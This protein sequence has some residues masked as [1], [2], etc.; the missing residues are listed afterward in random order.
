MPKLYKILEHLHSFQ[1]LAKKRKS[2]TDRQTDRERHREGEEKVNYNS[3]QIYQENQA[4]KK[5]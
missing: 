3:K 1:A 4:F 5:F 2:K